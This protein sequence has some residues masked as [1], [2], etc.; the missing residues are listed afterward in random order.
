MTERKNININIPEDDLMK[1]ENYM[2][3]IRAINDE[4]YARTGKRKKHL[5][6]T[7]GCQMNAVRC[8]FISHLTPCI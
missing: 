6:V 3:K 7:Y 4:Y 1:Q 2:D 8:I 5:T